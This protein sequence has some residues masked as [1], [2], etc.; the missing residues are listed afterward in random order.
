[1]DTI[2]D[3]CRNRRHIMLIKEGILL[4]M[5]QA[6]ERRRYNVTSSL[7]GWVHAQNDPCKRGRNHI[8]YDVY[9]HGK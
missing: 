3:A 8:P 5:Y 7:I 4:R 9:V 1:M 2:I 6:N